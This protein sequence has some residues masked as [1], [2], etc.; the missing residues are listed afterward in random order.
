MLELSVLSPIPPD[1]GLTL[2]RKFL[3]SKVP[4]IGST[5]EDV[6]VVFAEIPAFFKRLRISSLSVS[7]SADKTLI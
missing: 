7:L 2:I 6:D 5:E 4:S 3:P 1:L